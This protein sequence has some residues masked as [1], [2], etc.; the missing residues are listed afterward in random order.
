MIPCC[1]SCHSI[2]VARLDTNSSTNR[3]KKHCQHCGHIG[4]AKEFDWSRQ[5]FDYSENARHREM[6]Q[7]G[8][9][10]TPTMD[11]DE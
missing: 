3:H 1:P 11:A 7:G 6:V 8:R 2:S 4:D 10:K 9:R 5:N